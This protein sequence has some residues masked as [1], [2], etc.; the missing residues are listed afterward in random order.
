MIFFQF[1]IYLVKKNWSFQMSLLKLG[2]KRICLL[3]THNM[4]QLIIE[5]SSQRTTSEQEKDNLE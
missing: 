3:E 2:L 1:E 5:K 4:Y